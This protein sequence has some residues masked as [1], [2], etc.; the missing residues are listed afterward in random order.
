MLQNS[1]SLNY[2]FLKSIYYSKKRLNV[3]NLRYLLKKKTKKKTKSR[4][5]RVKI[6][7]SKEISNL[8]KKNFII[9]HLKLL[10]NYCQLIINYKFFLKI[11]KNSKK[12]IKNV[13]S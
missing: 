9:S 7:L 3:K 10:K 8:K 6:K 12:L 5:K 2:L 1:L 4:F 11:L 13:L